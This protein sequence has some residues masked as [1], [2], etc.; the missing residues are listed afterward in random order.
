MAPL[1][2]LCLYC[3]SSFK[4]NSQ[5]QTLNF[6]ETLALTLSFFPFKSNS[7]NQ[8]LF[9]LSLVPKL[10]SIH[11]CLFHFLV[12][13]LLFPYLRREF[14]QSLPSIT[15]PTRLGFISFENR[16]CSFFQHHCQ[17]G[18]PTPLSLTDS[19]TQRRKWVIFLS[20]CFFFSTSSHLLFFIF[21]LFLCNYRQ[22]FHLSQFKIFKKGTFQCGKQIDRNTRT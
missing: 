21:F 7:Q 10:P 1:I 12:A 15:G 8:P 3:P 17:F 19:D 11:N 20:N 13:T 4:L 22:L 14:S 2:I 18:E 5:N 9:S 16:L 6:F